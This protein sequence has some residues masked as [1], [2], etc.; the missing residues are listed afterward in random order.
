MEHAVT[1]LPLG[2]GLTLFCVATFWLTL[3]APGYVLV[4]HFWP[5]ALDG[6]P[7]SAIALGYLFTFAL[8]TPVCAVLYTFRLPMMVFT[9][10]LVVVM[11]GAITSLI[12]ERS[13]FALPKA[14][15]IAVLC[16]AIIVIDLVLGLHS[17]SNFGGDG[18]Y[19]TARVR[20]LLVHGFNNWDPLVAGGRFDDVYHSNIYHALMAASAQL[21][22]LQAPGAWAF[23]LF[24]AKLCVC[25]A[26]YHLVW[27]VFGER[28]IAWCASAIFV[29]FMASL[30]TLSY[31][32]MLAAYWLVPLGIAFLVEAIRAEHA[33]WPAIG[34]AATSLVLPGVHG[35]YYVFFAM[36]TGPVLLAALVWTRTRAAQRAAARGLLLAILAL[37]LGL[38][39][40]G[41]RA[42]GRAALSK[43]HPEV[44]ETQIAPTPAPVVSKADEDTSGDEADEADTGAATTEPPVQEA[45]PRYAR[46]RDKRDRGFVEAGDGKL[47]FDLD[48]FL[49]LGSAQLQLVLSLAAGIRFSQRRKA[50]VPILGVIG[51]ILVMLYVPAVCTALIQVAGAPW[52]VRRLSALPSVLHLALVP[53]LLFSFAAHAVARPIVRA[54]CL[55]MG[56]LYGYSEGVDSSVWTREA[57]VRKGVGGRALYAG[58]RGHA[59]KRALFAR[60]IPFGAT[61]VLPPQRGGELVLDCDCYPFALGLDQGGHGVRD[62]DERRAATEIL[63]G[64]DADLGTRVALLRR[65]NVDRLYVKKWEPFRKLKHVYHNMLARTDTYRKDRILVLDLNRAQMALM[66][67]KRH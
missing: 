3:A 38:P 44:P 64:G 9:T 4:R 57:Y 39:W 25:A 7:L 2:Y 26:V 5:R 61:V 8:A 33:G 43:Q 42:M 40:F 10:F 15:W 20:M 58:L 50:L 56:V 16:G 34:L 52:I 41:V 1:F 13:A 49:D 27:T 60:T 62:L 45:R 46:A 36:I 21:T 17:G 6:G 31:P 63:L 55:A 22:G 11:L 18:R 23:A 37:G 19:H 67:E 66:R 53:A 30:S 24:F 28:W 29:V 59:R 65:Y 35:L 54:G 14:S 32:N 12:R 48:N 51:V 47:M